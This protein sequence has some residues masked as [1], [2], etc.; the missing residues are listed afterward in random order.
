MNNSFHIPV[1]WFRNIYN[2]AHT[3]AKSREKMVTS[4]MSVKLV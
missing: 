1:I 3:K 2:F 4:N